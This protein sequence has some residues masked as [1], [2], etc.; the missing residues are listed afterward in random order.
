L[1]PVVLLAGC[2]YDGEALRV[3]VGFI[4]CG[5][6]HD[7]GRCNSIDY[8]SK[9]QVKMCDIYSQ[10][11]NGIISRRVIANCNSR[12]CVVWVVA[13]SKMELKSQNECGMAYGT[14][15]RYQYSQWSMVWCNYPSIMPV[16]YMSMEHF[17][18]QTIPSP[19][20]SKMTH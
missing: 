12:G 9:Q 20:A 11:G 16:M 6:G 19:W 8:F 4:D 14:W 2:P 17:D 15:S 3:R 13:F 18:F 1:I 10:S 5:E 7:G